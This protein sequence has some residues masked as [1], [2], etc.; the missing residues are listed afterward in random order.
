MTTDSRAKRSS[1]PSTRDTKR[2][3]ISTFKTKKL[4]L[5]AFIMGSAGNQSVGIWRHP[6]DR[7]ADLY[8]STE[9]WMNLAKLLEKGKFNAVFLADVLGPYDVYKGPGNFGPVARAGSQWP[10]SDPSYFIPLMAAVTSKLA[11]LWNDHFYN[12]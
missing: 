7:S 3:Q 6:K 9:Y 12:K 1:E 11:C 8:Q 5:N 10:I 4:I 2:Q